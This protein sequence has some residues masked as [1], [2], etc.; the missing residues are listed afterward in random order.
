[1]AQQIQTLFIDD[2]DGGPAVGTVRF[3]LDG[4][5]YE[6]DLNEAHGADL[7]A[8][9]EKYVQHG[10]EA[11]SATAGRV[12]SGK[13]GVSRNDTALIREWAKRNG[14]PGLKDRG[15]IPESIV[16]QYDAAG[17][18]DIATAPLPEPAAPETPAAEATELDAKRR[19]KSTRAKAPAATQPAFSG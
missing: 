10:R 1:M 6:I 14:H 2:I 11:R 12:V 19:A 18:R 13:R 3:G 17:G 4:T 9:L 8:I 5:D 16:A 7:R 15:R